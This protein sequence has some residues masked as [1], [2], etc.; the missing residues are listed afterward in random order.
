MTRCTIAPSVYVAGWL[1]AKTLPGSWSGGIRR[2]AWTGST[3]GSAN[4][5][6][7]VSRVCPLA[8]DATCRTSMRRVRASVISSS[9]SGKYVR[10]GASSRTSPSATASPVAA[11]VKLLLSEYSRCRRSGA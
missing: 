10:T 1:Y 5:S 2:N 6:S 9:S 4:A 3:S 11:D 7:N 8:I